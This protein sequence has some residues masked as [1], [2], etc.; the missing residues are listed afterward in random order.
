MAR[1]F[2]VASSHYLTGSPPVTVAGFTVA[3]FVKATTI[4]D[5]GIVCIGSG[6]NAQFLEL[7]VNS[8]GDVIVSQFDGT[9]ENR[10][11]L[12][13]FLTAGAKTHLAGVFTSNSSRALYINGALQSTDTNVCSANTGLDTLTVGCTYRSGTR[14]NFFDGVIA[15]VAYWSAAL[16]A[17]EIASLSKGF[18]PGLVRPQ[19]L[20]AYYPLIG[21]NSPEPDRSRTSSPLTVSGATK[22]DGF[23]IF[24]PAS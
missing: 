2:A 23:P 13:G 10:A 4:V 8:A 11:R 9:S 12:N 5:A 22:A 7:R 6:S 16:T 19:S 1:N 18:S 21:N 15:E 20:V 24:Y 14:A 3:V 17:D